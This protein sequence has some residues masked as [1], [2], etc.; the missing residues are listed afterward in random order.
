MTESYHQQII[1]Q[2]NSDSSPSHSIE[3]NELN[4]LRENPLQHP[5]Y[6][7]INIQEGYLI[8]EDSID[9]SKSSEC[10]VMA[11]IGSQ[12]HKIL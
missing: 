8:Q 11:A 4:N 2:D 10:D 5:S 1:E 6:A 3:F 9:T 7:P 12:T